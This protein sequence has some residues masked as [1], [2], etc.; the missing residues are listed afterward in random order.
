M[1][2]EL[3]NLK[4]EI[5]QKLLNTKRYKFVECKNVEVTQP[6]LFKSYKENIGGIA[7]IKLFRR[8]EQA[9]DRRNG[10]DNFWFVDEM[11]RFKML[12][13]WIVK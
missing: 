9:L 8:T 5:S 7:W 1:L 12:G 3:Q 10:I 2:G 4:Y 11:F 6:N 13:N